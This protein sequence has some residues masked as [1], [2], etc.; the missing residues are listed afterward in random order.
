MEGT[1]DLLIQ[2]VRTHPYGISSELL[3]TCQTKI[4]SK[5]NQGNEKHNIS[6]HEVKVGEGKDAWTVST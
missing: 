3:H 4:F 6:E 1:E 2:I 5:W